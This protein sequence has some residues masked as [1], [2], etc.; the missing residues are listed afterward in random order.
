[1][2]VEGGALLPGNHL[3]PPGE[4]VSSY[5]RPIVQGAPHLRWDWQGPALPRWLTAASLPIPD[6]IR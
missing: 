5:C 1:M 2:G 3:P 6:K 4:M